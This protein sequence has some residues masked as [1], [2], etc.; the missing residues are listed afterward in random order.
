MSAQAHDQDKEARP[1]LVVVGT[2]AR[3]LAECAGA[4]GFQVHALDVFGDVDTRRLARS[5]QSIATP[6]RFAIDGRALEAALAR[7]AA[8]AE[9]LGWIAGSGLEAAP[10]VLARAAACLPLL[11]NVAA[12]MTQLRMPAH[13]HAVLRELG[14]RAPSIRVDAPRDPAGWLFKDAHACGGWHVRAAA[15]APAQLGAGGHFQRFQH[16]VPMSALFLADG[17]H[18]Q[19][20]TLSAQLVGAPAP[21]RYAQRGSLGPIALAARPWA[22]LQHVLDG[23]TCAFALRGVNGIDFLVDCEELWVLEVNPRPTA[24]LAVLDAATQGAVLREHVELCRG[25]RLRT[26]AALAALPGVRASEVV[27]ASARG[28]VSARAA[29]AL[30]E[31]DFCR[32][33]PHAGAKFANGDPLCTVLAQAA[34]AD[35]ARA[36]LQARRTAVLAL[37]TADLQR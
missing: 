20:L 29:A 27:F 17:E 30:A 16:G 2:S 21:R 11:G 10:A 8:S 36:L 23:L 32:D 4:G 7:F 22:Q 33:L 19:L 25:A 18:W 34:D 5:W 13:F 15:R 6:G 1:A 35:A 31:L 14:V 3:L 37:V 26:T 12:T 9:V 24:S 28:E